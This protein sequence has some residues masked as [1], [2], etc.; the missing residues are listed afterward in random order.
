MVTRLTLHRH[1]SIG[2]CASADDEAPGVNG[3]CR[4]HRAGDKGL[5]LNALQRNPDVNCEWRR[6]KGL[7]WQPRKQLNFQRPKV[8]WKRIASAFD[9]PRP[10]EAS[11][12]TI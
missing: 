12:A 3:K 4:C 1:I 8:E 5:R 2:G 10:I 9:A 11:A 7:F 6:A